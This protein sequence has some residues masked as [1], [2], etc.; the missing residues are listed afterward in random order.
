MAKFSLKHLSRQKGT[1]MMEVLV[2]LF[3]VVTVFMGQ[4]GAQVFMQ[5][6]TA[7]AA[8]RT[9]AISLMKNMA[10]R[11]K[12]NRAAAGCYEVTGP[13]GEAPYL[14][15]DGIVPP[16]CAG[17]GDAETQIIASDD[18]NAWNDMLLGSTGIDSE[19]NQITNIKNAKGCI[20]IDDLTTPPTII[21]AVAWEGGS[22]Q[23]P[24]LSNCGLGAYG[25]ES[26][27]RAVQT[28]I[29]FGKLSS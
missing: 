1:L 23:V 14:G 24:P 2:S 20:S 17:F 28:E 13:G 7:E 22:E 9:H 10:D 6:S 5:K 26:L 3:F 11:M 27:R 12:S 4:L 16:P 19:G 25:N 8:Q 18:L 15:V 21:I 29:Q